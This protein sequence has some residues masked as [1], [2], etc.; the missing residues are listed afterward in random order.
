LYTGIV[1]PGQYRHN[2]VSILSKCEIA[3]NEHPAA[4]RL[5][6]KICAGIAQQVSDLDTKLELLSM[7][8][9]WMRLA[10]QAR[11]NERLS[12]LQQAEDRPG[13]GR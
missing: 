2:G 3:G 8:Q 4:Y 5:Q 1:P 10:E 7:A 6:A 12:V 11:K 9:A 13:A